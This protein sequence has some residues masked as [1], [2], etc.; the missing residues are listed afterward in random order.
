MV[1]RMLYKLPQ[2]LI[3]HELGRTAMFNL[4]KAC[5][6]II[7]MMFT[8]GQNGLPINAITLGLI[9]AEES[10]SFFSHA[11]SSSLVN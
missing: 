6:D 3:S 5:K 2:Q 10:L 4:I 8:I 1:K 9:E 7:Y 11:F